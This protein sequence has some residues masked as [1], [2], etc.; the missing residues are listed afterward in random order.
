MVSFPV[1]KTIWNP[2]V[3]RLVYALSVLLINAIQMNNVFCLS[4]V[5]S[6]VMIVEFSI[7][8]IS[9]LYHQYE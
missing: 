4:F 7:G 9:L 2:K 5:L 6:A 8:S 1:V 3:S